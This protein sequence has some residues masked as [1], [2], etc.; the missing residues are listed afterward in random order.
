M[1]QAIRRRRYDPHR[2]RSGRDATRAFWRVLTPLV[3]LGMLSAFLPV[4]VSAGIAVAATGSGAPA[5]GATVSGYVTITASQTGSSGFGCSSGYTDLSVLNSANQEVGFWNNTGGALSI[6]WL[7][8]TVPNGTY[9]I[10]NSWKSTGFVVYHCTSTSGSNSVT[11]T[12]AN[13]PKPFIG[14]QGATPSRPVTCPNPAPSD[15]NTGGSGTQTSNGT[16][17]WPS[18]PSGTNP[19]NYQT[20]NHTAVASP[21]IRPANW[22]DGNAPITLTSAPYH[23]PSGLIGS[24]YTQVNQNP[25]ELCGVIGNS[26]DKAWQVTTGRPTTVVAVLD[27]GIEWCNNGLVNKAYVNP[28]AL[29]FPENAQGL[30][31][32]QLQAQGQ[33]FTDNNP[34]DLYDTGVI[35]AAQ[36]AQDPRVLKVIGKYHCGSFISPM[37]LINAFGTPTMPGAN[38]TTVANPYYCPTYCNAS[39]SDYSASS[40]AGFTEAVSGWNFL[41][42]NNNPE[43]TVRYGHG[44]GRALDVGGAAN[45]T[46]SQPG[47]CLNCMIL[48]V[49]TGDSFIASGNAF[50]Q[51]VLFA[52]DSGASVIEVAMGGYDITPTAREAIAYAQAHGVPVVVASADEEAQH[53]NLPTILSHTIVDSSVLPYPG[54]PFGGNTYSPVTPPSSLF[55]NGCSNYGANVTVAVESVQCTSQATGVLAGITGLAESAAADAVANGTLQPYPGLKTVSGQPVPLSVNEIKQLISMSA[56]PVNFADAAGSFPANNYGV[57]WMTQ[58]LGLFFTNL[59]PATS[60]FPTQA[61]FNMYTGYGRVNAYN[62]VQRIANGQI[63]PEAEMTSPSWFQT[64]N[65]SQPGGT[66]PVSGH[67]AAVRTPG[68][69]TWQVLVGVGP[70]PALNAYHLVAQGSGQGGPSGSYTGPLANIPL[71]KIASYFPAGTNFSQPPTNPNGSPNPNA[72]TFTILLQVKASNGLVGM[73]RRAG[74]LHSDPTLLP[75]FPKRLGGSI[76]AAPRLAPIGPNGTNVL[77]VADA[78]G[79]I[80]AYLPNGSELPGWPVHTNYLAYHAGEAAFT[81][82]GVTPPRGEIIGGIAVGNL[83]GTASSGLDIVATD[84]AG[85]VYAWNIKGQLLP[86]FPV[87]TNPV[88]SEA[89]IANS[90][91]RVLPGIFAA[92]ALADLQGNGQLDIVAPAMDRHIYA[93]QPNGKLVPGWPVLVVDPSEVKSVNWWNNQVTFSGTSNAQIGT[94]LMD[95]P[96]IGNLN[97]GKGPPDVIVGSN[98]DYKGKENAN[99]KDPILNLLTLTVDLG[100]PLPLS[101]ANS[102]VYAIYPNGSLHPAAKGAPNPPGYPNPGAF[103]PGWP[104]AIANLQ[105]PLLPDIG[106]GVGE[107]PTLA[108]LNFNGQLQTSVMATVGPPYLLNPNGTSALG[109]GGS[110]STPN[111]M[112]IASFGSNASSN[113]G[114]SIPFMGSPIVAPLNTSSS[115]TCPF[116]V[117]AP[118][119]SLGTVEDTAFPGKQAGNQNQFDAWSACSGNFLPAFPGYLNSMPFLTQPIV[120]DIANGVP[121]AVLGSSLYD[122]R[123]VNAAGQEAPGFPK[124]TGGWMINSPVFGTFGN[125]ATQVLVAGTREGDLWAWSTPEPAMARSGPWP[126]DHHDLWNTNNLA[127]VGAP[128][129]TTPG[130]VPLPHGYWTVASDGGIFS[131]G[132]ARFH[133][134]M[135]GKHLNAPVTAM[136]ST[137]DGAGYWLVAT[138]GGIFAFG[139]AQFHGSMGGKHL[140][141]PIVGMAP[142]PDG[143]G[144]WLVAADGGMF[145]FGDAK[146][147]GSMGGKH[148][149]APIVAMAPTPDGKGYWLVA[150]DGGIFAFGDAKFYGSMGGRHLNKPVIGIAPTWD[151][152]GYWMVATDG[153]IFSFGDAK[154]Y[155]SMGGRPLNKPIVGMTP[156]YSGQGYWMDATDGGIFSF[157]DAKF[158]GSMGGRPL[159]KPMVGM[160]TVP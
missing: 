49:R 18:P 72:T 110:P 70:Q 124:F 32:P 105:A 39:N 114:P 84:L 158:Y 21:P 40:P 78:D 20:Y 19:M 98:E 1:N 153:G 121:Y 57:S 66:V 29:P 51:G 151:G 36:W 22:V 102:R 3:V 26:V 11:V 60:Q 89:S 64:Y 9:T 62:I 160:A 142:T 69:F 33:T 53:H 52:V 67:V 118:A 157:G 156:T 100:L 31:K 46:G 16:V 103:L 113:S 61:G 134:S 140:N 120:A 93:W 109:Y 23:R 96:A 146:F 136:A 99:I 125:L 143:R 43:D 91:N 38:G 42:N 58:K 28:A 112:N 123:A 107:S 135:G 137:A 41:N 63:P 150:S 108:S 74:F 117:I 81:K 97:G 35:N 144:Y 56:N 82:G 159:N 86:G 27:S 4:L 10:V 45:S 138:D 77:L 119:L 55:L 2:R 85:N 115:A 15:P 129:E 147:Y 6:Q 14:A 12:V 83:Y 59:L 25:Q 73:A 8:D 149:N 80:H 155:G 71:S 37:D 30:T 48:P 13:G 95:T 47:A 92:P 24:L 148:L 127:T 132:S 116:S 106:N 75:G 111:V 7:S 94:K 88:Y 154:F 65:P 101:G 50:A 54:I 34:Y 68:P 130:N 5:N 44:T 76:D 17:P 128:G 133:G 104:A 145:A 87:H 90:S 131:F 122:L 141:A 152:A 126:Q 79:T 139:D